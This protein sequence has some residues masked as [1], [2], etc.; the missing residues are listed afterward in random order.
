MKPRLVAAV[1]DLCDRHG[2]A[3]AGGA[4]LLGLD[5]PLVRLRRVVGGLAV[6]TLVCAGLKVE[7]KIKPSYL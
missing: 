5:D 3:G 7:R 2:G 4:A 6:L 1:P